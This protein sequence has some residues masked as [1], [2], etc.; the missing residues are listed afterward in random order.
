M[1]V[2]NNRIRGNPCALL[3]VVL[4]LV[5]SIIMPMHVDFHP[6]TDESPKQVAEPYTHTIVITRPNV[7]MKFVGPPPIS[8]TPSIL[9]WN[10]PSEITP[11]IFHFL[12]FIAI[13][14][15]CLFLMPV[16]FTSAFV[17]KA[18]PQ[19]AKPGAKS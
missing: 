2:T 9:K 12:A 18:M 11:H 16:K 7:M 8:T 4:I 13:A 6:V 10:I 15:K 17:D 14:L 3:I 1:A 19:L 5:T